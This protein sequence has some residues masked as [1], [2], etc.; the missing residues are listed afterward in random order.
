MD[1]TDKN[2]DIYTAKLIEQQAK[3][4]AGLAQELK[5]A[6]YI[7]EYVSDFAGSHFHD[8]HGMNLEDFSFPDGTKSESLKMARDFL[9]ASKR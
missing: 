3:K 4:I 6:L 8:K 7:L 1:V 9:D 5:R 2:I